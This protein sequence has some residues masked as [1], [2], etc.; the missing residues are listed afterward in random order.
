MRIQIQTS[1][2][3]A[4]LPGLAAPVT[5]EVDKLDDESRRTLERLVDEAR[6]FEL[7][8]ALP[9]PKG[10]ADYQTHRIT[11]D[12]AGRRHTVSVSDPVPDPA[13]QSLVEKLRALAADQRRR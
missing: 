7:P 5:I 9:A 4:Y 6:F 12:R 1:G 13:L 8:A 11:I 2:G 3:L 10:A